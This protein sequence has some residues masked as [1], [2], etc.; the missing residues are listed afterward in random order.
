MSLGDY[1]LL[2]P[3]WLI[4]IPLVA[5][6]AL[7]AAWRSAPLGDWVKAIDPA[8]MAMLNRR[9][10]VLGGWSAGGCCWFDAFVTDSF[11]PELRGRRVAGRADPAAVKPAARGRGRP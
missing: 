9:G 2:R 4:A 1:A 8:L 5:A 10:A 3:L 7:R 6:L 11:G